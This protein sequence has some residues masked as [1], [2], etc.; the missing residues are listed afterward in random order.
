MA[1]KGKAGR[2]R[3]GNHAREEE[4]AASLTGHGNPDVGICTTNDHLASNGESV[5]Y[6]LRF[7]YD[8]EWLG[9]VEDWSKQ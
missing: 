6:G 4:L 7:G 2:P 9:R 3:L 1:S 5:P 8:E